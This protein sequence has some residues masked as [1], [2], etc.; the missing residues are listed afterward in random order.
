MTVA[1]HDH[2]GGREIDFKR[3][4]QILAEQ[5]K[6]WAPDLKG[7]N[8]RKNGIYIYAL[9]RQGKGAPVPFYVGITR[10]RGLLDEAF[11]SHKKDHYNRALG[12]SSGTPCLYFITS[13]DPNKNKLGAKMLEYL[14]QILIYLAYSSNPNLGNKAYKP[15]P[16]HVKGLRLL[17]HQDHDKGDAKRK[18][19]KQLNA[20][21]RLD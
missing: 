14:E 11:Y 3:S 4:K 5:I 1:K 10:K 13:P 6:V 20:M 7:K 2:G 16:L 18:G 12:K 9:R 15:K 19:A 8:K 21:F 17:H